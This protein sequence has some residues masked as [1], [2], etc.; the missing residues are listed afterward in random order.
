M[1][2]PQLIVALCVFVPGSLLARADGY[3]QTIDLTPCIG[4]RGGAR[5]E[6]G[7]LMVPEN[8]TTKQGRRIPINVVVL[9]AGQPSAKTAV[10]LLAGGPGQGS[11]SMATTANGWMS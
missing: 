5:A 9:R 2:L 1:R 6:C 4:G 10:F 8:R 7:Q 3:E 11:T